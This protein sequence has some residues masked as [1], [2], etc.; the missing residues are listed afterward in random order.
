MKC[1]LMVLSIVY[2]YVV[3]TILVDSLKTGKDLNV[4]SSFADVLMADD[5]SLRAAA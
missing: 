5:I 4:C 2:T 1:F 3:G